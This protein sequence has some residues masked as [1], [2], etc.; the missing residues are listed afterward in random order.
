M[1]SLLK[2]SCVSSMVDI[3]RI[4]MAYDMIES[5]VR[6]LQHLGIRAEMYGSLLIPI[7]L[8]QIPEKLKLIIS[9]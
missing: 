1:E 7:M 2:L 3:E 8:A 5:N 4:R 9:R 6:S